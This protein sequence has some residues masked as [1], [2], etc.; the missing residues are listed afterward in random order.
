MTVPIRAPW[1]RFHQAVVDVVVRLA[2]AD[3]ERTGRTAVALTGGV[4]GLFKANGVTDLPGTGKLL[5]GRQVEY[6]FLR[7]RGTRLVCR[8]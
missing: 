1:S 7:S 6:T 3:R 8:I 4:A 5:A 2:V